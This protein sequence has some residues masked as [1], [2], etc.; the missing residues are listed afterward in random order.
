MSEIP[1]LHIEAFA[2]IG[3]QSGHK[4]KPKQTAKFL[5]ETSVPQINSDTKIAAPHLSK[6]LRR[7]N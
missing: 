1:R 2:L 5:L 3:R 6:S 4:P 7:K